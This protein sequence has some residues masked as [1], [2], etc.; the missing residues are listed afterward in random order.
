[1]HPMYIPFE[2][3]C[4]L[5]ERVTKVSLIFMSNLLLLSHMPS[6]L[7][8]LMKNVNVYRFLFKKLFTEFFITF[9]HLL[10]VNAV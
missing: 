10:F 4:L 5:N 6:G 9:C 2:N 3:M 8:N 7:E 1:M